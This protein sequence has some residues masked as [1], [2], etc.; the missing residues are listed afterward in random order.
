MMCRI[1]SACPIGVDAD[2]IFVEADV[3]D[4]RNL[5]IHIVGLPDT[6]TREAKD[7]LIPALTNSGFALYTGEIV[8]NLGPA[9]VRKEGCLYDL[10][11]A[12]AILGAMGA[13]PRNALQDVLIIGELALDGEARPVRSALACA[14]TARKQGVKQLIVPCGNGDEA[15]LVEGIEVIEV[16]NLAAA[17]AHLRGSK[18]IDPFVP[19]PIVRSPALGIDFADVKGQVFAKR[20]LEIAAAGSHNILLYGPPGSGKSM[21]SK[22]V[23][24]ILPSLTNEEFIEVTRIYSCSGTLK[25]EPTALRRRPFRAPHHTASPIAMIGGGTYPRPGEVTL[26][27]K[28]VLFLDEFP[29]FPRSVLE[30][31]RQP[32]EDREVT[33]S[34]ASLQITFPAD[35]TLVAAM[36]PCPCGWR[37]DPRKRCHCS[38]A[39][40]HHYRSR[41]S[42]PI[43]DR[44]DMHVEVPVMSMRAIRKLPPAET[45]MAIKKRVLR[46]R[47]VQFRRFQSI[48]FTN[49]TMQ[50]KQ[51]NKHCVLDE[52]T[53]DHLEETMERLGYST[54]VHDKI[55]RVARTIADLEGESDIREE[56]IYEAL[57]YRSLDKHARAQYLQEPE[58][59]SR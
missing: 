7:R 45:S 17:A 32:L 18:P 5:N 20:A 46:A 31:L 13:L 8:I 36:N 3:R 51:L 21:L 58:G 59:G 12:I 40:V 26:A 15:S 11:M 50:P 22:R 52:K 34:R 33:I 29:E 55:L 4:S 2:P 9:D 6:A 57:G 53:A 47:A 25:R 48:Q 44:I 14:E 24:S 35:F 1:F 42:G 27:H 37:G 38:F 19:A 49:A 10:P 30:V 56:H 43:V 23:P 39:Q 16:A 41:I 54:R 28:G